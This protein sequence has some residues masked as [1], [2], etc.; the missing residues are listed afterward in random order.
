MTRPRRR[1]LLVVGT[2]FVLALAALVL[3]PLLFGGRIADR[4]KTEVNRSLTA[5]VDWQDA[6]LGLFRNFPNLT[7]RLDDLTAVGTGKFEGDTLAAVRELRVVLDLATAVRAALG[8]SGPIVVRAVELDRPRLA[9]VKLEDGSANWDVTRKDTTDTTA[10]AKPAARPLAVSLQRFAIDSGTVSFDNRAA[11]LSAAIAGLDQELTG[12]FAK[13]QLTIG[14]RAH[15]DSVTLEFAGIPYLNGVRL[16][17]STDVAADLAKKSFTLKE[18]GVRLNE[19]VLAFSGTVASAGERLALD[20]AFGAPKTEFK[21]ILSLVPAVYARDF[22]SVQA[23]GKLAVSG[24]IEGEYGEQAFPAFDL[25]A[26]VDD[27]AFRYPDLPLPARDIFLDLAVT[28]PGDHADSTVVDLSRFHVTI[29][30]NP[31]DVVLAMRT[32]VSDPDVDVRVKGTLDLAD[33]R[34]TIKLEK[35]EELTGTVVADAAVRTRM[36]W[37]DEGRYDRVAARGTV[38]IRDLA[39]RSEALPHPLAIREASLRLAPSR[40]E[41]RSLTGTIGSSDL[42]LSGTLDN[43]LGYVMRDQDL[44]GSATLASNRFNLEEWRSKEG[45]LNIIPVPP[46][47]DFAFQAQ[48]KELLFDKLTMTDARGR[49]RV[50]DQRVTLEDFTFNTLGGRIGLTGFYET[51]DPAKP[52]FDVGLRMQT[53]D[54]PSAFETLTTVR[55]LAPVARYAHG[56]FSADLHVNGALGKDMMPLYQGLTGEGSILTSQLQIQDFPALDKLA[57]LTK[58][59]FLSDPAFQAIKSRFQIRDGRLHVQPFT[60]GVGG[61]TMNVSGS[62]GLDQSLRYDLDLRVPRRLLGGAANEAIGGLVSRAAGAGLDLQAAPEIA[63]G[64]Q[65]TGT[66]TNPAVKVDVGSAAG[67]VA[68]TVKEAAEQRVE[69]VVDSARLRAAAEAQRLVQEAET[70][71]EA[72]RAEARSL[73]EKV[74]TEG[75]QQADSLVARASGPFAEAAAGLA[76]DKLRKESDNKAAKIVS[77]A[78]QR[79]SA[80]VAEA[81]KRAGTPA[82]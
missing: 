38:D 12:D 21:H 3:L 53:V 62:N 78:D 34:R 37:V 69:E 54:I 16:D 82:P 66:V 67:S 15:A 28:N 64:I 70:R 41:L 51:T 71:A 33:V 19:L 74:K 30:R 42:R 36:S 8:G 43:L 40:S 61:T 65:L 10:A 44:R 2:L 25:R 27:G 4:V 26:R 13:E 79:A 29:G 59:G 75:Y 31:V 9:L 45:D 80:L 35:L 57:D 18:S 72:I 11:R 24:R 5:R 77:E 39:V 17:L 23:S 6:G 48:V 50:K 52:A 63:L 47:I 7:L 73:A 58:L 55:M 1:V 81:R 14:T 22:Q 32:P 46:K 68:E 60:V 49:L 20:L 76:A 56:N